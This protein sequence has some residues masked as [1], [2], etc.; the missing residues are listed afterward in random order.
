MNCS[1]MFNVMSWHSTTLIQR[2][3]PKKM[4]R[5]VNHLIHF[6]KALKNGQITQVDFSFT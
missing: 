4:R 5:R 3:L 2:Y 1:G 6:W